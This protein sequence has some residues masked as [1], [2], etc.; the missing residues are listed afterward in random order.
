MLEF[1]LKHHRKPTVAM[2]G[3]AFK[4]DIDDLRESPSKYITAKVMQSCSNAEILVVE[5]NVKEH[6]VFKLTDYREAYEKADIVAFLTAHTP[7]R[8]LPWREDKVVLDFAGYSGGTV[9]NIRR[10]FVSLQ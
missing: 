10:K 2:M 7:F 1:E 4:P 8:E 6:N 3:L 9:R 5:P